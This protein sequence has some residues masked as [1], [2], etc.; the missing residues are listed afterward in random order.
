[1]DFENANW[2]DRKPIHVSPEVLSGY[3]NFCKKKGLK[4][5]HTLDKLIMSFIEKNK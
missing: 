4:M 5:G 3:K 1:M 2:R